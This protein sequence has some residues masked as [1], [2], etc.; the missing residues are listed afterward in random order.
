MLHHEQFSRGKVLEARSRKVKTK[1]FG[2]GPIVAPFEDQ[3]GFTW[4]EGRKG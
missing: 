2:A 4:S 3:I 1:Q